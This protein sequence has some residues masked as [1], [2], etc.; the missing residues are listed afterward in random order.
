VNVVLDASAF[1]R[2]AERHPAAS[3]WIERIHSGEV[4]GHAPE[5]IYA[6]VANGELVRAR[7][8]VLALEAAEAVV[9]VLRRLPLRIVP[10]SDLVVPAMRIAAR[11]RLSVYDACYLTLADE[12]DATLLTADRGLAG[13]VAGSILFD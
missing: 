6:E 12:A 11:L 2:A 9:D 1:I 4:R 3:S 5:L 8:G 10:S 13:A 7:A